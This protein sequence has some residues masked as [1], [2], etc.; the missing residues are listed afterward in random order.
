M[1]TTEPEPVISVVV[2]TR[3]RTTSVARLITA[4]D[5]QDMEEP[6]DVVLVDDGSDAETTSA[7][8]RL[9]LS[10][11][12]PVGLLRLPRRRGPAT[13]RNAGWRSARA[14]F[15]AFTDDDCCPR[16]GWLKAMVIALRENDFVQG[17]T[18]PDGSDG[19]P[20]GPFDRTIDV[21]GENG[22]YETSS[23]GYRRELLERLDGFDERFSRAAG[24][25]TDLGCRARRLGARFAF[26]D[27]AVVEHDV[28]RPGL[29]GY[30]RNTGRWAG[31]VRVVRRHPQLKRYFK[32]GPFWLT[33]HYLAVLAA[34]GLVGTAALWLFLGPPAAAALVAIVPY[35]WH[36]PRIVTHH[37]GRAR[38][39]VSLAGVFLG[40]LLE[41]GVHV[42]SFL[43]HRIS[44]AGASANPDV[45]SVDGTLR[46]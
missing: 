34:S 1:T 33:S 2:P 41:A 20:L 7:L 27:D 6:F 13:A 45:R 42:A 35:A 9:A 36:R 19:E 12:V 29:V 26:A 24:E 17:R 37:Q 8:R 32:R 18:E 11:K 38:L 44:E 40:D 39:S 43:R 15:V 25:D 28:V 4:L 46:R 23:M 5:R 3:N 30:L 22:F 10:A 31:V 14:P 21:R 16:A